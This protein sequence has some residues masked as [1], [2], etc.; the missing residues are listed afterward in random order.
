MNLDDMCFLLIEKGGQF[1]YLIANTPIMMWK[2]KKLFSISDVKMSADMIN[3][4]VHDFLNDDQRNHYFKEKELEISYS[5]TNQSR[6][7]INIYRQL[8]TD[9]VVIF[10]TPLKP[11]QIEELCLPEQI[12]DLALN[13]T[14][15]LIIFSGPKSS[16]KTNTLAAFINFVLQNRNCHIITLEDPVEF[17]YQNQKGII[18]QREIRTDTPSFLTGL[19]SIMHQ[20]PDIIV[21]S[22]INEFEI[23][24]SIL[25]MVASGQLV[26]ATIQSPSIMVLLEQLLDVFPPALQLQ[27]RTLLSIGLKSAFCQTLVKTTKEEEKEEENYIPVFE[28]L[29]STEQVRQ[30]LKEGKFQQI[31]SYMSTEGRQ[32][33]MKTQEQSLLGLIK[34]KIISP[35][36]AMKKAVRP[37]ELK[38]LLALPY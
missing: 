32:F 28:I 19:Q 29:N 8:E 16:G 13:C 11:P 17:I 1:L 30:L 9:A 18:S 3:N 5:P 10:Q 7:R 2:N 23:A 22:E 34:K 37:E 21:I 35:E 36:E 33:N 38:K 14:Q 20:G 12:A 4:I 27:A 24:Y 6:F 26:I 15:G 31:H 25:N